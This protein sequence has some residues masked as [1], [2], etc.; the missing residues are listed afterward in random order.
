MSTRQSHDNKGEIFSYKTKETIIPS[1][2][3]WLI[4]QTPQSYGVVTPEN[5]RVITGDQLSFNAVSMRQSRDS[6]EKAFKY[7]T[8]NYTPRQTH[9]TDEAST[10][11]SSTLED[12]QLPISPINIR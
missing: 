7:K 4:E 5:D 2:H 12:P 8:N 9:F 1:H 6:R 11:E 10:S 3:K